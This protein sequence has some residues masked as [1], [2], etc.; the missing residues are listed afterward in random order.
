MPVEVVLGF[1]R[2]FGIQLPDY[3]TELDMFYDFT[4]NL[5]SEIGN[6][7]MD[8][9]E[10]FEV[11]GYSAY[12]Q[13]PIFNRSWITTNYLAN[14]YNFVQQSVSADANVMMGQ[15]DIVQFVQDNFAAAAPN[16]RD[17]IIAVAQYFLPA[18]DN[19][20]FDGTT[21][22]LTAER[23]N[24]FLTAFLFAPQIDADPEAQWTNR[25]NNGI[26]PTTV[27]GQLENLFNAMLQS[28]EYQ[29]M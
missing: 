27:A 18:S 3:E 15:V 12:H 17:L 6:Q 20:D 16:A 29:L 4:G 22:E 21:G 9:Y 2:N 11:A 26:D 13:F 10:P 28:P 7:G 19:L 8:Y 5:L 14:R 23:L 1:V 24:Y 25:W